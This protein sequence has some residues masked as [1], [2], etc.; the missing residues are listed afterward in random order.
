MANKT[1][2]VTGAYGGIGKAICKILAEDHNNKI[3]LTGR[4]QIE[5]N[6]AVEQIKTITNN[7]SIQGYVVDFSSKESIENFALQFKDEPV[8]VLINNHATGPKKREVTKHG[9]EV[10]FATNVLGYVWMTNA[11]ENNLKKAAPGARIVNVA[12]Y[13]AGGLDINDLEF[14]R[15]PYTTDDAY[16]QAKQ[17]NRMLTLAYAEKFL[18]DGITVNACHPGDSNTKL[19]NSMGFGGHETPEKSAQT[20]VYLAI[21]KDVAHITGKYFRDCRVQDD[22]FMKDREL[23]KKLYETC[24][25]Y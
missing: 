16:Q 10:Q 8:H 13:W 5:L 9:I 18:H 11:F 21:S 23:I 19:S 7:K 3:L 24:Q 12:S 2:I 1:F 15:R 20:P 14:K 4:N 17:A 22:P 25:N 6:A